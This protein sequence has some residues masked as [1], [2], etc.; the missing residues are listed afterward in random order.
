M[1]ISNE[2]KYKV[3][4]QYYGCDFLI[5]YNIENNPVIDKFS[6]KHADPE[7]YEPDF[8][9][10]RDL[11]ILKPLSDISRDDCIECLCVLLGEDFINE[12]ETFKSTWIEIFKTEILDG[13]GSVQMNI[14]PYFSLV[15]QVQFILIGKGYDM[16]HP[17]LGG[18]TLKECDLCIYP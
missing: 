1:E 12:N 16:K 2:I 18:K 15:W 8:K 9:N 17:L 14:K 6:G 3:A 7:L 4:L 13:F 5:C 11:L 10:K